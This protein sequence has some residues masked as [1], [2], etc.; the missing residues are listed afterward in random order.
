MA[1]VER[2]YREHSHGLF[3]F[4][5]RFTG[6]AELA[7][8]AVQEAFTRLV[9]APPRDERAKSWLY[10][11][12]TNAAMSDR[13]TRARR[14]RLLERTPGDVLHGDAP[15]LPDEALRLSERRLRTREVLDTLSTRDRT[16]LLMRAEGFSHREIAEAVGTTTGSIGTILNRAMKK[17]ETLLDPDTRNGGEDGD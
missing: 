2:L 7:A 13:R 6:D 11:V 8:D 15:A 16:A 1:D 4:L 17:M 5:V 12:A 14:R 10:R 3:R 9:A